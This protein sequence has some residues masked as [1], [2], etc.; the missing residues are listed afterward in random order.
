[1]KSSLLRSFVTVALAV[2][3]ISQ[4]G[5]EAHRISWLGQQDYKPAFVLPEGDVRLSWTVRDFGTRPGAGDAHWSFAAHDEE[6]NKLFMYTRGQDKGFLYSLSSPTGSRVASAV[7]GREGRAT[8]DR[9]AENPRPSKVELVCRKRGFTL[10]VDG[11]REISSVENLLPLRDFSFHTFNVDVEISDFSVERVVTASFRPLAEPVLQADFPEGAAA[12]AQTPLKEAL[13]DEAGAIMFWTRRAADGRLL[14]LLDAAGESVL[15]ASLGEYATFGVRM[16]DGKALDFKRHAFFAQHP[17]DWVHLAFVWL[18]TGQ[19]RLFVNGLPYPTG[20]V[21]GER[22]AYLTFSNALGTAK[23][24]RLEAAAPVE[25]LRIYRREVANREVVQAYRDRMRLDLVSVKSVFPVGEAVRVPVRLAPGG[26]FLFPNPVRA[27]TNLTDV[28]D[29]RLQV[30]R[31]RTLL[32]HGEVL[33]RN[34]KVDRPLDVST[35]E[36]VFP[37][38]GDYRVEV[39]IA[40]AGKT[41]APYRR[42]F[43]VTAAAKLDLGG[44]PATGEP[45]QRGECVW[46]REFRAPG[47]M[48]FESGG[49]FPSAALG[50]YLEAGSASQN[51]MACEI[52]V[53]EDATGVPLLMDVTWPDDKPRS[54]AFYLFPPL[55]GRYDRDRLQAGIQAGEEYPNSGALQKA[56][57]LVFFPKTNCLW[58][59][60]TMIAGAPA[61]VKSVRLCRLAG[62]M[63]KLAVEGP[64]G[65]PARRFGHTDEDQTFFNNLN[66]DTV[67]PRTEKILPYLLKYLNYTGQDAF[68]YSLAR[69]FFQFGSVEGLPGNGLFPWRQGEVGYVLDAFAENGLSFDVNLQVGG[70]PEAKWFHLRETD[71]DEIGGLVYDREGR[72]VGAYNCGDQ[73]ANFVNLDVQRAFFRYLANVFA[74]GREGIGSIHYLLQHNFGSWQSLNAG[75]GDWT[76]AEFCRAKGVKLPADCADSAG[77]GRFAARYRELTQTHREAWLKWRSERVTDFVRRLAKFVGKVNPKLHLVLGV[78]ES[79][80]AEVDTR[81]VENGIDFDA[82]SQIPNVGFSMKREPTA[83]RWRLF[84]GNEMPR[85]NESLYDLKNPDYLAFRERGLS[86]EAIRST[87][88][89]Y[90]T[91][92]ATLCP[93]RYSSNF[94]DSDVKPWGRY[95][96]KDLAYALAMGDALSLYTGEQPLGSLGS[97]DVCREWAREYRQLPAVPFKDVPGVRDPVTARYFEAEDCTYVYLVNLHHTS[98]VAALKSAPKRGEPMEVKIGLK[99][100]GLK[101]LKLA[102]GTRP[103]SVRIAQSD[104]GCYQGRFAELARAAQAFDAAG[105][106]HAAED[107]V[108]AEA[109]AAL[110]RGELGETHR[111]LFKKE[112]CEMLSK[113]GNLERLMQ[114]NEL[115]EAGKVRVNCGNTSYS[116]V[117]GLLFSPEKADDGRTYGH[118]GAAVEACAREIDKLAGDTPM[119]TLYETEAYN[120]DGYRFHRLPAGKYRVKL[121]VKCGWA[122]GWKAGFWMNVI[123]LNGAAVRNPMDVFAEQHG[124]FD[125]PAENLVF[126]TTVGE[127]G[128]LDLN[129]SLPAGYVGNGTTRFVNG[130]VIEKTEE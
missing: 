19:A 30:F 36:L 125:A 114:E 68:H 21:P 113:L 117:D 88:T 58:E 126:E 115:R 110:A 52:V 91:F 11:H 82:L 76:V 6:G 96:L 107:A 39:E 99:P 121:Y 25:D 69:Y 20:N 45:W 62:E 64:R 53:P 67:K 14:S 22:I 51:R 15:T 4:A 24:L 5:A 54:M 8:V 10:S 74:G 70:L 35:E 122:K 46:E 112:L 104:L 1:M 75:Y 48:P 84:R 130:I 97:E 72:R 77:K 109:K 63:P 42:S 33:A 47:D 95:F 105:L 13:S 111:L 3:A 87:G 50:G 60:R 101:V 41:T 57:Y 106:D 23:S 100:F 44:V 43:M 119:R 86:V 18:P 73:L 128:E 116:T 89:Y 29:V 93:A 16:L 27:L 94:Q 55:P 12:E 127:D 32:E 56:T 2:A 61:A 38:P 92:A 78:G 79:A 17:G 80:S 129:F 90:E 28:V 40:R 118:Y 102:S 26:R 124:N 103:E 83:Q 108:V 66:V 123:R 9:A 7:S 120:V 85:T 98:V 34:L 49:T 71:M 37:E 59:A 65:Y 81:Y 31:N